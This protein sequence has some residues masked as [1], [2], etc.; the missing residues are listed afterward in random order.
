MA[1]AQRAPSKA[2]QSALWTWWPRSPS[3]WS[4]SPLTSWLVGMVIEIGGSMFFWK[5]QG[6]PHAQ[7]VLQQDLQY[8]AAA[9]RSVLVPDTVGFSLQLL[10]YVRWPYERLGIL[11]WY[12]RSLTDEPIQAMAK[13]S[14]L[15]RP[16]A[17][18]RAS[19]PRS[20]PSGP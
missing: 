12:Q 19:S 9:P 10:G 1:T 7:S 20:Q 6:I 4:A 5:G 13:L 17:Q 8:I 11:R 15:Y 14:A 18:R 3:A 16:W 2:P